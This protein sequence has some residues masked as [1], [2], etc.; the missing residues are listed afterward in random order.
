[1][2]TCNNLYEFIITANKIHNNKYN[3]SKT[4]FKNMNT[5]IIIICDKHEEFKKTPR[6][7]LQGMGC[8]LC[9]VYGK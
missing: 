2:K 3:Y 7:H 4:N 1:M 8:I 6:E 5:K 9:N